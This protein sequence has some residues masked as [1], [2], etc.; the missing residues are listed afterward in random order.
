MQLIKDALPNS[1]SKR[2]QQSSI[3]K[4]IYDKTEIQ[5]GPS[6]AETFNQYF[7]SVGSKLFDK[8]NSI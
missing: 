1:K 6:I 2:K 7:A 5:D 8:I 4:L 3:K